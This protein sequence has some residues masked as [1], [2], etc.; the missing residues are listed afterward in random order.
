MTI[1]SGIQPSGKLH[2]GN[3]LGAVR[4]W[5]AL[6]ADPNNRCFFFI[7]DWHSL[8]EEYD[9]KEKAA[10]VRELAAELLAL[11][12]GGKHV[13]L[14]RQS[15]VPEHLELAWYLACT[16]PVG[17]LE[18]MTQYK[19]KLSHGE[20]P[21]V[22]LF[23]Y[24]V[25]MAADI[26]AYSHAQ[27][28]GSKEQGVRRIGVPVGDDQR[29][30]LELANDI[31][32][33]FNNRFGAT[34]PEITGL[35]TTTPR[36]MSLK[37]PTRKMSKSAGAEHCLLLDDEPEAVTTKVRGAVTDTAPSRSPFRTA[38]DTDARG[39]E[40]S[41]PGV[42]TLFT[43]LEAYGDAKTVAQFKQQYHAGTIKYSELKPAVAAAFVAAYEEFRGRKAKL[44][45]K[46]KDIDRMLAHG[47][48]E[49]R[50]FAR[51]TLN[52]V[53]AQVGITGDG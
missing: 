19:D 48:K 21:T 42:A 53:R 33:R 20:S 2:V 51:V 13:A 44:M 49:A 1:L 23:A 11:G 30:H 47:A 34:F 38:A 8:T 36:I 26:L 52:L 43:I 5:L 45:A 9:P 16:A 31:V 39:N 22:G 27:G 28:A 15:D 41:S 4:Q 46:P 32:R 12:I 50:A 35:S 29:Q 25:L 6:Q 24:P 3:A 18:R 37:D 10:Q 14:F 40:E 7:A 17:E